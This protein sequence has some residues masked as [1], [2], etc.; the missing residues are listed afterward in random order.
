MIHA[1]CTKCRVRKPGDAF[2]RN[3]RRPNGLTTQ[4][5]DE[6]GAG[7]RV[8]VC[9][10]CD[11]S[12]TT[13]RKAGTQR[14]YCGERCR[15]NAAADARASRQW[16]ALRR[17]KCG[18]PDVA[19]VGLAVCPDCKADTRDPDKRSASNK[20]RRFA[21]YGITE[22]QFDEMLTDQRGQCAICSTDDPGPRG[23]FIDHDHAC[24]PGIGSCGNCVRGLLCQ[25]C[26]F[27]LGHAKD[28]TDRLTA[29]AKY[30]TANAQFRMPLELVK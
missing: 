21:L 14:I 6:H 7:P 11:G 5:A 27:M 20:A 28:S 24:C 15:S 13:E 30:L 26:N 16:N 17:C 23:W 9:P 19:Q 10:Q 25:D 3:P 2:R 8:Q 22:A 29:A 12:F 18:S 4:C 1:T